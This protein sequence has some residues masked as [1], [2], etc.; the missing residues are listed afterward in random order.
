MTAVQEGCKV[1]AACNERKHISNFNTAPD[2]SRNGHYRL[3]KARV[4]SYCQSCQ[5]LVQQ[6]KAKGI[7]LDR[8]KAALQD[9]SMQDLI[10][11]MHM[12]ELATAG[13]KVWICMLSC[14]LQL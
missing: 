7:R 13:S 2:V 10:A 8:L 5:P 12:P 11:E 14:S 3:G 9:G 1:C 6:C 4:G